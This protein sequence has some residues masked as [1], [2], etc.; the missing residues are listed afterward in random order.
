ML[1]PRHS[2]RV[3]NLRYG[4]WP[5]APAATG[6]FVDPQVSSQLAPSPHVS[7]HVP[8][9]V[10]LQVELAPQVT[11]ALLPTVAVHE[12]FDAQSMLQDAPQE[13]VQLDDSEHRS[14]QL[15]AFSQ[16]PKLHELPVGQLQLVPVQVAGGG[17]VVSLPQER[18]RPMSKSDAG[19]RKR[20]TSDPGSTATPLRSGGN[21]AVG[22]PRAHPSH[23][24]TE[25]RRSLFR[26]RVGSS[27]P[28]G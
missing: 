2:R 22:G 18:A 24:G 17:P 9:Q 10:I 16:E 25:W 26:S 7:E 20:E 4:H 13:P 27:A 8:V 14:E 15:S 5:P 11:L 1:Q 3:Q 21:K 12:A 19:M 23:C 28:P 6:F